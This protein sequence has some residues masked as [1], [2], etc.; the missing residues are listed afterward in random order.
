MNPDTP[1]KNEP[2]KKSPPANTHPESHESDEL[3]PSSE[4]I[5]VDAEPVEIKDQSQRLQDLLTGGTAEQLKSE[6][7][8]TH[9]QLELDKKTHRLSTSTLEL[10]DDLYAISEIVWKKK[11]VIE[12]L[13]HRLEQY[14]SPEKR[15]NLTPDEKIEVFQ[16]VSQLRQTLQKFNTTAAVLSQSYNALLRRRRKEITEEAS[17]RRSVGEYLQ[18]VEAAQKAKLEVGMNE[19]LKGKPHEQRIAALKSF[20]VSLMHISPSVVHAEVERLLELAGIYIGH[21]DVDSAIEELLKALEY[22]SRNVRIYELLAECSAKKNDLAQQAAYLQKALEL[23]PDHSPLHLTLAKTYEAMN[24]PQPA[25]EEY[26]RAA[27]IKPDNFELITHIGRYAFENQCWNIAIPFLAKVL[28]KKPKSL[29]T[30]RRLGIALVQNAQYQK[31]ISILKEAARQ[32]DDDGQVHQ[33]LGIAH[34]SLGL[35]ADAEASFRKA[36]EML[37]GDREVRYWLAVS[38][39][40]GGDDHRAEELARALL[41]ENPNDQNTAVLLASVLRETGRASQAAALLRPWASSENNPLEYTLELGLSSLKAGDYEEAYKSFK[42][43]LALDPSN[44]TARHHLGLSCM[45]L[46]RFDESLQFLAPTGSET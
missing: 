19:K 25:L 32:R 29:K 6:L 17:L 44:E 41:S 33:F 18:Y 30:L 35:Y 38:R 26:M 28:E 22:D 21:D 12:H 39:R 45:R 27:E 7:L 13:Q 8:E 46:G 4:P 15:K 20:I 42:L 43:I 31:G 3:I 5:H 40:D 34:R 37:P 14:H 1:P 36:V 11:T 2:R 16:V 23:A 9:R 10:V 24:Q